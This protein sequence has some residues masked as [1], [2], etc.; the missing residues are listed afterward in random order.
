MIGTTGSKWG[1]TEKSSA[2][3]E[4]ASVGWVYREVS[5]NDQVQPPSRLETLHTLEDRHPGQFWQSH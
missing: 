3:A 4:G 1:R 2:N 5:F